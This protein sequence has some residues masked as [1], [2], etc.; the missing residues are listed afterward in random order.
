MDLSN[1]CHYHLHFI[2]EEA[3]SHNGRVA[4]STLCDYYMEEE[5]LE[6]E[7]AV[8]TLMLYCRAENSIQRSVLG[9]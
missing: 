6:L 4:W 7:F 9:Q 2:D 8:L 1:S 3:E 5:E